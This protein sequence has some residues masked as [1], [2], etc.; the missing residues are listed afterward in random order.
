MTLERVVKWLGF[1]GVLAGTIRMG[2]TPSSLKFPNRNSRIP[3]IA[4]SVERGVWGVTMNP[5]IQRT[6]LE[7]LDN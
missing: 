1:L 5:S 2:M 7:T 3:G 4:S 6:H